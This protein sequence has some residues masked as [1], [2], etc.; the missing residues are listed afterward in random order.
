M[1]DTQRFI[2]EAPS[3]GNAS[4]AR[5]PTEPVQSEEAAVATEPARLPS[6]ARRMPWLLLAALFLAGA[7]SL[8]LLYGAR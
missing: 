2:V 5:G 4:E 3:R 1:F 8:L 6:S 7:L